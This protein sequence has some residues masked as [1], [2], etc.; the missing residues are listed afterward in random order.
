M[1]RAQWLERALE[2]LGAEAWEALALN[3]ESKE[4]D[5]LLAAM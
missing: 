5:K 2:R 4:A 1:P 3:V